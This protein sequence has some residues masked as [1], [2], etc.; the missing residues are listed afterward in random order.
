R[1]RSIRCNCGLTTPRPSPRKRWNIA[2][3][4]RRSIPSSNNSTSNPV[5]KAV[6]R[7]RRRRHSNRQASNCMDLPNTDGHLPETRM[8]AANGWHE[9]ETRLD[10][11]KRL[12]A[13]VTLSFVLL[14]L[15]VNLY[16]LRQ[17][18][19]GFRRLNEARNVVTHYDQ[20]QKPFIQNF[21]GSLQNFAK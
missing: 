11:L 3:A 20:V 16:L 14:A 19:E 13:V 4:I 9:L 21:A 6:T 12:L 1:S 7:Q 15:S 10:A 2:G 5:R 18:R 17:T 8:S